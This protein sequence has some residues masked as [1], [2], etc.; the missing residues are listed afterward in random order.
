MLA[1]ILRAKGEKKESQEMFATA[2]RLKQEKEA[3]LS[4]ALEQGKQAK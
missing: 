3:E 2:A 4:K 1:Q